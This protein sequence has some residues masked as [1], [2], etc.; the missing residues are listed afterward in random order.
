MDDAA[1]ELSKARQEAKEITQAADEGDGADMRPV[2]SRIT[3][4]SG[5]GRVEVHTGPFKGFKGRINTRNDNGSVE[6]T[7]AIFGRDTKVSLSAE[8]FREL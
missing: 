8:E 2:A 6:A 7:L 5:V 4:E 3:N 1:I